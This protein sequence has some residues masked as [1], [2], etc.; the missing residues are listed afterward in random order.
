MAGI[1]TRIAIGLTLITVYLSLM[2]PYPV[3][4]VIENAIDWLMETLWSFNFILPVP[5][6]LTTFN[7]V[8]YTI[9]IVASVKLLLFISRIILGR[10][11]S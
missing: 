5:T 3:P 8:L 10:S 11:N 6:I 4:E 2:P 9:T 7:I 1:L